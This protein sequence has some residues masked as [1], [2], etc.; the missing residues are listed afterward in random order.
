M[1]FRPA[2]VTNKHLTPKSCSFMFII[3]DEILIKNNFKKCIFKSSNI[4]FYNIVRFLYT[5]AL[6]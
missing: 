2:I 1:L 5:I 6:I 4:I 3:F